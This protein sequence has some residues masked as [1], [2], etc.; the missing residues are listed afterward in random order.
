MPAVRPITLAALMLLT[1]CLAASPAA[2]QLRSNAQAEQSRT[3][4]DQTVT[5]SVPPP[6]HP[7]DS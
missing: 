1:A 3:I 7:F 5:R 6:A 2:A 4:R